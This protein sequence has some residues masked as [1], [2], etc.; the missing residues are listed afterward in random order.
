VVVGF[1]GGGGAGGDGGGGGGHGGGYVAP[2][3]SWIRHG[4]RGRPQSQPP[5]G[6]RPSVS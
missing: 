3:T 6:R 5:R 4:P 1:D 2:G